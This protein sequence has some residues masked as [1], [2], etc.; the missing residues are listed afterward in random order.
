MRRNLFFLLWVCV[1]AG[2]LGAQETVS[3]IISETISDTMTPE[4]QRLV[5]LKKFPVQI[6]AQRMTEQLLLPQSGLENPAVIDAMKRI[7]RHRFV[8]PLHQSIAYWDQ[9]IAIGHSQ[10]ISPPYIVA[11]MTEQ[12]APKPADKV[13]EIGTGSGYQ[14]AVLSLLVKEVYTIE[15]IE[16]LGNQAEKLLEKLGMDNVHVRIGDGYQGWAEAA[17]FDSIIVTCSPESIPQP[18]IDQLR[19]GGRM[20]I[21]VG[22]RFQQSF[23]LCK[24]VGGK[25]QK[26]RL[27]QTLFVPMTG[28]AEEQRNVQPDVKNPNL[29]GGSFDEVREDGSPVGWHYVR[30]TEIVTVNDAP[31]GQKIARFTNK[32]EKK[33]G[34]KPEP[35]SSLNNNTANNTVNKNQIPPEPQII[36]QMLQGFALDGREVSKLKI[37]YWIRGQQI[38]A[39]RGHV[40]TPTGII[41]FYDENRRQIDEILLGSCK[42]TFTWEKVSREISVKPETREAVLLIGLPFAAG[43]LDVHNITVGRA[44]DSVSE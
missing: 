25:L 19:E 22:E 10:T 36:A 29:V 20:V 3:E 30:N 26:E 23:Y 31:N 28:E 41:S 1:C 13:L 5:R 38:V 11:F 42:G 2:I 4:Q 9:A 7:P 16:P 33:Q 21:P 24:K 44:G 39:R 8:P 27:T 14:A 40:M 43:Q 37:D 17:P 32:P 35:K 15:I 6:P 12:L 18:L 34:K